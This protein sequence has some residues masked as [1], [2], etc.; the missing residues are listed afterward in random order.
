MELRRRRK[1]LRRLYSKTSLIIA[2]ILLI[3][4]I[5]PTWNILEKY[6]TSRQNLE[7]A[8]VELKELKEREQ[9]LQSEASKL[10]SQE[11]TEKEILSKFDMVREGEEVAVILPPVETGDVEIE[12]K[13][14]W[15]K[16]KVFLA[17]LFRID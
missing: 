17:N 6:F 2:V 3:I 8:K 1:I 10:K 12:E 14:L 9:Y 4:L 7:K 15:Q 5:R 16:F 13:S 11:G